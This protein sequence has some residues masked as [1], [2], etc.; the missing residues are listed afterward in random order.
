MQRVIVIGTT[1]SGK[2][3]ASAALAKALGVP[4]IELDALAWGPNW[5]VIAPDVLRE[6]VAA[7]V[8]EPD[9]V[10]DG[11][12]SAVRDL[13]WPR[14]DTIV[15][16][17]LPRRVVMWRVTARTIRRWVTREVLWSGN[18]ETLRK[19]LSRDSII[20]WAWTTYDRRLRDY[21]RQLA[22]HPHVAVVRLRSP[23]EVRRF[24]ASISSPEAAPRARRT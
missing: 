8:A 5:Q 22:A 15:W 9:W 1:G 4:H 13:T 16:L 14:A 3:I 7:V 2:T 11:N 21:P 6:R 10:I 20:V 23:D 17:D 12:Y 18:R 19:A 24:L